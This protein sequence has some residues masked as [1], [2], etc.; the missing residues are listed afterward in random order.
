MKVSEAVGSPLNELHF[1][2]EPFSDAIVFGEPPSRFRPGVD[3]FYAI[4]LS[5]GSAATGVAKAIQGTG[6]SSLV[7]PQV[8]GSHW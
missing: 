4:F 6:F 2:M 7:R 8:L 5:S 1:S 3:K